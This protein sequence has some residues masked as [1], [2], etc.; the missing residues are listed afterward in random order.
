MIGSPGSRALIAKRVQE[1]A[2]GYTGGV[3]LGKKMTRGIDD[4]KETDDGW[5]VPGSSHCMAG[6]S[7]MF[8]EMKHENTS[9]NCD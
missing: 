9:A 6:I 2:L 1:S 5:S 3:G 8:A 7:Y 4:D